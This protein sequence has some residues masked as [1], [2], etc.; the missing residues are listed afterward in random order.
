MP[1]SDPSNKD[2]TK[3]KIKELN[4]AT[5]LDIGCGAGVYSDI[6]REVLGK[7]VRIDGV[8]VWQP[9]IDQFNLELK[10]DTLFNLDVRNTNNFKYDLVI[11]GDILEHMSKDDAIEVWNKVAKSAKYGI[12]SIPIIHYPQGHAHGNPY[13]EHIKDDWSTKEILET[14]Q[15]IVEFKE[16]D[17]TGVFIA[18]F[19]S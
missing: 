14:F 19:Q 18:K 13:E 9:Y 1:Y 15:R 2:W 4:P 5:V 12:I 3:E 11:F 16:F 17:V 8:E 7:D 10:Y 6:V